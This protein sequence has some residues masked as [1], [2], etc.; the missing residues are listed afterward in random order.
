LLSQESIKLDINV[1]AKMR[2]GIILYADV[3]RPDDSEK[4]PAILARLP[5]NK[6]ETTSNV[7]SGYM[8]PQKYVRAGYAVVFQDLRGTGFFEGE[9]YARRAEADDGYD[10]IEWLA[11][12]ASRAAPSAVTR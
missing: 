12:P 8:N 11:S 4:H 6:S 3:Y 2:D 7:L 9:F 10:T 5:Y 1:P